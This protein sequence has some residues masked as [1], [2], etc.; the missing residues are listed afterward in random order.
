M[1]GLKNNMRIRM[2][3]RKQIIQ[4]INDDFTV[5]RTERGLVPLSENQIRD[6]I[7][8]NLNDIEKIIWRMIRDYEKECDSTLD[9]EPTWITKYWYNL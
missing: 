7:I 3:I 4:N 6:F 1:S 2:I 5:R 8:N 9:P